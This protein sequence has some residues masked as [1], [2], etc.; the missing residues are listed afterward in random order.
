MMMLAPFHSHIVITNMFVPRLV[1]YLLTFHLLA[2]YIFSQATTFVLAKIFSHQFQKVGADLECCLR[3][4]PRRQVSEL[5]IETFRQ[6]H[7]EISTTVSDVDDCLMFSNASLCVPPS[8]V[9]HRM[10]LSLDEITLT[11]HAN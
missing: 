3:D 9:W 4:S 8:N 6:K 5:E 1:A 11:L 10:T 2:A 7:Q